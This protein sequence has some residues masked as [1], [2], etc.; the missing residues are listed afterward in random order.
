[1]SLP[2]HLARVIKKLHRELA[3]GPVSLS[4]LWQDYIA[5]WQ[6]LGWSEAQVRLYLCCLSGVVVMRE[7]ASP[8]HD[9][10]SFH[11]QRAAAQALVAQF[12]VADELVAL[13]RQAGR[14][15][16]LAQL[17]AKMPPGRVLTEAMLRSV[18]AADVR[19]ILAGPT[20]RLA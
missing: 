12:S 2:T 11:L 15:M 9:N 19:L 8:N 7:A 1:M 13:L 6:G 4:Q 20:V 14:P 18:A 5:L 16:L 17:L 3:H 10:I